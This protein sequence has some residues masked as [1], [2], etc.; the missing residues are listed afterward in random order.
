MLAYALRPASVALMGP[1]RSVSVVFPPCSARASVLS[2]LQRPVVAELGKRRPC[3][4]AVRVGERAD[5]H[6]PLGRGDLAIDEPPPDVA[7]RLKL[8]RIME[9][10]AG[11]Q[12]VLGDADG[13]PLRPPPLREL[14]GLRPR[15]PHELARGLEDALDDELVGLRQIVGEAR[16]R[17]HQALIGTVLA[18]ERSRSSTDGKVAPSVSRVLPPTSSKVTSMR[19][20]TGSTSSPPPWW[21][22]MRSGRTISSKVM[23]FS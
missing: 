18:D 14:F 19:N 6:Q 5:E 2:H 10:A 12:L 9:H 20:C 1:P 17:L 11:A 8:H 13:G 4:P 16:E 3:D 15:L 21:Y 23:R 22:A 7:A